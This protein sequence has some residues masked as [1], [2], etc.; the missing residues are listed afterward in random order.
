MGSDE[1]LRKLRNDE[2]RKTFM[3]VGMEVDAFFRTDDFFEKFL[4]GA[5]NAFTV[6]RTQDS[7]SLAG[8]SAGATSC[9]AELS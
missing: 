4:N 2:Y 3:A 8:V 7:S 5:R 1:R 6:T 9:L